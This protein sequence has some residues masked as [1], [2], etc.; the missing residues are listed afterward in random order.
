MKTKN[1]F[2]IPPINK[3]VLFTQLPL[4]FGAVFANGKFVPNKLEFLNT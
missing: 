1:I 3:I 4:I 2:E